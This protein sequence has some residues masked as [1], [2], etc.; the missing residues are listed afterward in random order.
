MPL[1]STA[2]LHRGHCRRKLGTTNFTNC[3]HILLLLWY[4]TRWPVLTRQ[5]SF[6]D[7]GLTVEQES[8]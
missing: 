2:M 8:Q 5:I 1:S 6:S 3:N 4:L 7:E